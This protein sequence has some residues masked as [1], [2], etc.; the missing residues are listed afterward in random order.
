MP[1]LKA[2]PRVI[3]ESDSLIPI[4]MINGEIDSSKYIINL[5]RDITVLKNFNNIRFVIVTEVR[6]M[7]LIG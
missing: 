3:V 5:V 2:Y 7:L 1:R 6:T 4:R